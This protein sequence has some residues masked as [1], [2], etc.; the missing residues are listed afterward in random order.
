MG[1]RPEA[2]GRRRG[3]PGALRAS[4]LQQA[5]RY[6]Q[7]D[8][9]DADDC[10]VLHVPIETLTDEEWGALLALRADGL[11]GEAG[12]GRRP[13]SR[14][15]DQGMMDSA[16]AV[17]S[18]EWMPAEWEEVAMDRLRIEPPASSSCRWPP[19]LCEPTFLRY[20]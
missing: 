16:Q 9:A 18:E 12:G 10:E 5:V 3:P 6:A 20:P 7:Y 19:A 8:A 1:R 15:R 2:A 13:R 11:P 17:R 4:Q 14:M